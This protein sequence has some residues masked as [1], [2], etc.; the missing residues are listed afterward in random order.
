MSFYDDKNICTAYAAVAIAQWVSALW[1]HWFF[2]AHPGA[3]H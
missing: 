3:S 2:V 1:L